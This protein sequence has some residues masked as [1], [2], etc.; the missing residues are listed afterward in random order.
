MSTLI[1]PPL[2]ILVLRSKG[3]T[4]QLQLK[5]IDEPTCVDI[6]PCQYADLVSF[7][8][9]L[10]ALDVE[11]DIKLVCSSSIL[12]QVR[13]Q[14]QDDS[15]GVLSLTLFENTLLLVVDDERDVNIEQVELHLKRS[16]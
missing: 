15:I 6:T 16:T 1:K 3:A 7:S 4:P 11:D 9:I 8:T 13:S 14:H 10:D 2:Q 12:H 5:S